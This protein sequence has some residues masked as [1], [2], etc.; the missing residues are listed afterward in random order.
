[1][2]PEGV[3]NN[4]EN[5]LCMPLYPGVYHMA[6]ETNVKVVPIVS[7]TEHNAKKILIAAGD[8]V[9]FSG[10]GKEESLEELRDTLHHVLPGSSN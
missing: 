5:L 9:D 10:K 3:L 7:H 2:F 6:A 8:P 4:S 1:M